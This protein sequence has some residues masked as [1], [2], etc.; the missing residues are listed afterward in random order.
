MSTCGARSR[1]RRTDSSQSSDREPVFPLEKEGDALPLPNPSHGE[2]PNPSNQTGCKGRRPRES[3]QE[4]PGYT[5]I[6]PDRPEV[7]PGRR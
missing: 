5:P 6:Y 7:G 4:G 1:I 3:R 2:Q